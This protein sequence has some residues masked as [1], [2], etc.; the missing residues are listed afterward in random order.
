MREQIYSSDT[1]FSF[2]GQNS[3]FLLVNGMM[4]V[5]KLG[6]VMVGGAGYSY[7][8]SFN[9]SRLVEHGCNVYC[10]DCIANHLQ[11][12]I[13]NNIQRVDSYNKLELQINLINLWF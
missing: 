11:G 7:F 13:R 4:Y 3:I 12:M 5:L 1:A 10:T 8:L 9:G 2:G 6:D